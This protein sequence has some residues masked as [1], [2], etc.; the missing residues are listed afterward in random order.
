MNIINVSENDWTNEKEF[1]LKRYCQANGLL[2][3]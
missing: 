2:T 1:D 3:E